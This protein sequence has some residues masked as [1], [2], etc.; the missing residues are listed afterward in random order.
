MRY[1]LFAYGTL[2][3]PEVLVSVAGRLFPGEVAV[4][5]DHARHALVGKVYPGLRHQPGASTQGVLY[6]GLH[7]EHIRRLDAFEDFFYRRM[8]LGVMTESGEKPAEVYVIPVEYHHLL[9]TRPWDFE[10][11]ARHAQAR[12]LAHCQHHDS[13]TSPTRVHR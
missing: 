12:F 8:R 3:A 1:A 10:H 6:D 7:A 4:L 2:Q 13:I 11:F 9:D 5:P